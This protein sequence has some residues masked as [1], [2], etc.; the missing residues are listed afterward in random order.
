MNQEHCLYCG[1]TDI[2]DHDD[3]SLPEHAETAMI[4][5]H[6]GCMF[7]DLEQRFENYYIPAKNKT[8]LPPDEKAET[9]S[10]KAV[11]KM[12]TASE[13]RQG[14]RVWNT[15]LERLFRHG[16]PLKHPLE[17]MIYRDI[18]QI[19]SAFQHI[20]ILGECKNY[21]PLSDTALLLDV[22]LNNLRNMDYYLPDS[23]E[24]KRFAALRR[25]YEILLFFSGTP[26]D[27]GVVSEAQTNGFLASCIQKR[28]A[29]LR[30]LAEYLH[31]LKETAHGFEY[32]K[33]ALELLSR[34]LGKK[35]TG[36][37]MS[38]PTRIYNRKMSKSEALA[39]LS[40][41]LAAGTPLLPVHEITMYSLP[42]DTF[43][44]LKKQIQDLTDQIKK[45]P[46]YTPAWLEA[47]KKL[48]AA[49][50]IILSLWA[51]VYFF[52]SHILHFLFSGAGQIFRK[53]SVI[54][55]IALLI[56]PFLL[57]LYML[58]ASGK[59]ADKES[60]TTKALYLQLYKNT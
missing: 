47:V 15:A 39:S 28:I 6:C 58:A 51:V 31:G 5:R 11:L 35:G 9:A 57:L 25:L 17:F 33:M 18:C 30:A 21:D 54:V 49:A 45:D 8:K 42:Q 38:M 52:G 48:A 4:C 16:R 27:K 43:R 29:A 55:V 44:S 14:T 41:G 19:G 23:D 46:R 37:F 13:N 53:L 26:V 20:H 60:K 12:L 59:D 7:T 1:S 22:L 34:C 24:E 40:L 32:L 3:R 36:T 56:S 10:L 50:A 2:A